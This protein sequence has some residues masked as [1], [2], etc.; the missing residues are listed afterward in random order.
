MTRKK[1][2]KLRISTR[3][4]QN[5]Q[6]GPYRRQELNMC[7][8][9]KEWVLEEEDNHQFLISQMWTSLISREASLEYF[10]EYRKRKDDPYFSCGSTRSILGPRA[11][12]VVISP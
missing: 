5:E 11:A 1:L 7:H 10:L 6:R 4:L 12:L 8:L 9:P 3:P 2:L